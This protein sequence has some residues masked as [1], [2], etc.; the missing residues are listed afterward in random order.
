MPR[1]ETPAIENSCGYLDLVAV[2]SVIENSAEIFKKYVQDDQFIS[3]ILM[4]A[5]SK[6]QIFGSSVTLPRGL[7]RSNSKFIGR[8]DIFYKENIFIPYYQQCR[9]EIFWAL[10]LGLNPAH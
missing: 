9:G 7:A 3:N 8:E 6:A 10:W 4:R 2:C 5:R 1:I